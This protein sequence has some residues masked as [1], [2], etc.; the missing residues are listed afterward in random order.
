MSDSESEADFEGFIPEEIALAEERMFA[1]EERILADDPPMMIVVVIWMTPMRI[2]K[3]VEMLTIT[4][5]ILAMTRAPV[6][7]SIFYHW[8]GLG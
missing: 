3:R 7:M 6:K 2:T 8:N 1:N 5:V 4:K